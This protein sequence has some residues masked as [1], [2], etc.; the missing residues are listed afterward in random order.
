MNKCRE[1]KMLS[2]TP[3]H[4]RPPRP[5]RAAAIAA[6]LLPS[7]PRL[8]HRLLLA[9]ATAAAGLPPLFSAVGRRLAPP[10]SPRFVGSFTSTRSLNLGVS[11]G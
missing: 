8:R 11:T 9:A 7:S 10:R 4:N 1:H 5:P 2:T 3:K 6:P